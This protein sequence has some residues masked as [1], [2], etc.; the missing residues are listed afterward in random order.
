MPG[1]DCPQMDLLVTIEDI[2]VS[3]APTARNLGVVLDANITS[4]D[5]VELLSTT[6]AGSGPSS[7]VKQ[8]RSWSNHSS[9]L[10][11]TTATLSWLDSP[12]PQ[13]NPYNT[14]R[15]RYWYWP[16]WLSDPTPQLEC[17]AQQ[18][19]LDDWYHL[20]E[21]KQ[22]SLCQVPTLLCSGS[23]VVEWGPGWCHRSPVSTRDSR[24]TCSE[25][26]WTLYNH[27][28]PPPPGLPLQSLAINCVFVRL[29]IIN[30]TL[31][32]LAYCMFLDVGNVLRIALLLLSQLF[33]Q[34]T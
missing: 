16:L 25:F 27:R 12:P 28:L 23:A 14:S 20:H 22:T 4:V 24:L 1:K 11:L 2:K 32:Y 10:V 15:T 26:T 31:H 30:S 5:L 33:M 13:S 6:S 29:G 9:S 21:N 8:R 34:A 7:H 19:W 17:T 18:L 3:P